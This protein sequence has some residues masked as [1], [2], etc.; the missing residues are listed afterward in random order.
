MERALKN[1]LIESVYVIRVRRQAY[2]PNPSQY[3]PRIEDY[4]LPPFY[5][6]YSFINFINVQAFKK[7]CPIFEIF[8]FFGI[9]TSVKEFWKF[10]ESC[11]NHKNLIFIALSG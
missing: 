2:P 9:Q 3:Q 11:K 10:E 8:V 1:Y 5:Q 6:V 4:N 7:I